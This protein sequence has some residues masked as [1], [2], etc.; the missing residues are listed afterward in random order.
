M[1]ISQPIK[2]LARTPALASLEAEIIGNDG[3]CPAS[4]PIFTTY[5]DEWYGYDGFAH[6]RAAPFGMALLFV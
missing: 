2:N 1:D 4:R 3:E 6:V 5:W